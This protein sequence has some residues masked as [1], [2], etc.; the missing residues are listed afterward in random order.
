MKIRILTSRDGHP[1]G[2]EVDIED[3]TA[4]GWVS[5][6]DA[7]P[8][9]PPPGSRRGRKAVETATADDAVETRA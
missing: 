7:E 5:A 2:A 3:S 9:A 8:L 1:C 4:R 6:G